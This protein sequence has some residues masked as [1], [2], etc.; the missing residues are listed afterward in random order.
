[1]SMVGN[2]TAGLFIVC[3]PSMA[4]QSMKAETDINNIMRR[5]VATGFVSHVQNKTPVYMDV[6]DVRD[7][8][9]AVERVR[10]TE[11]FFK[12]LPAKVRQEFNDD[13]A[14]FLD[15]MADP[16]NA[17]TAE[18]MGLVPKAPEEAGLQ[19]EVNPPA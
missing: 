1:M 15:F 18:E 11:V 12:G 13:A 17:L 5:Y 2:D 6:S 7:Y 9:E 3:G 4:K 8:R 16:A 19:A 10:T 14:A